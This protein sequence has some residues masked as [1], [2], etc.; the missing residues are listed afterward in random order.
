MNSRFHEAADAELTEAV[1]Y[2]DAKATGLG[3]RFLEEVK[4]ATRKIE[5]YPT[6][7]PTG[8]LICVSATSS[9]RHC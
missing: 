1:S 3:D 6:A 8:W 4:A 2:Y 9:L 5:Q 7:E